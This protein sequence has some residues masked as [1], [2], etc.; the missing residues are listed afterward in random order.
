MLACAVQPVAP[1]VPFDTPTPTAAVPTA[2]PRANLEAVSISVGDD[3]R[4]VQ[5]VVPTGLDR[6]GGAT[7]VPLLVLLHPNNSSPTAMISLAVADLLAEREGLIV[8]LP[9]ALGHSWRGRQLG[10]AETSDG[11]DAAYVSGIIGRLV[12]DYLVDPQ[13]VAVAGFS[14]GAVLAGRIACERADLV[15]AV[16]LVGGTD[17]GGECAPTQPVSV[18]VVHGSADQTFAIT[19]AEEFADKW[20]ELDGCP[21][22]AAESTP[23]G[24]IVARTNTGCDDGT[25]VEFVRVAGQGHVWFKSPNAT[26]IM[27]SFVMMHQPRR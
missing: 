17:W 18:L 21:T 15:A 24:D 6:T 11:R 19:D 12:A 16:V 3:T 20:R 14:M 8:A 23:V 9:P 13:R 22:P 5:M 26:E 10:A 4:Q 7:L 25:A 27:W 2:L 1:S